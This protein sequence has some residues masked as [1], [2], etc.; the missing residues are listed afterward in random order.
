MMMMAR[1]EDGSTLGEVSAENVDEDVYY[2]CPVYIGEGENKQKVL[3][4]FDT[5]SADLWGTSIST[6]TN[7]VFTKKAL[8]DEDEDGTS[9][10]TYDPSTSKTMK[11]LVPKS[12]FRIDYADGSWARGDVVLVLRPLSRF[13]YPAGHCNGRRN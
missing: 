10:G 1:A 8:E 13:T 2:L 4:D 12:R 11:P 3:L 9:H 6:S 7:A 5:G